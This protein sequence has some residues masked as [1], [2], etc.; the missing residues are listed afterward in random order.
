MGKPVCALRA[1]ALN[2]LLLDDK[3][4]ETV[5][6]KSITEPPTHPYF[7]S[8]KSDN[9]TVFMVNNLVSLPLLIAVPRQSA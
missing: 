5:V 8:S 2:G 7:F 3:T 4:Y 6:V 1:S 9:A